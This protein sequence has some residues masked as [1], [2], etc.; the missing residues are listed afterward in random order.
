M[1]NKFTIVLIL[2]VIALISFLALPYFSASGQSISMLDIFETVGDLMEAASDSG[3]RGGSVD[4]DSD[5]K[6]FSILYL[7]SG[8]IL[9]VLSA[10]LLIIAAVQ[11]KS[12]ATTWSIV[13][14]VSMI[15]SVIALYLIIST[16]LP[17]KASFDF[18]ELLEVIGSGFWLSLIC[19]AVNI[20]LS[21]KASYENF[22]NNDSFNNYNN[23]GYNNGNYN[24]G[25]Y[26]NNGYNSGNNNQSIL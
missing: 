18:S 8:I 24:N 20:F 16:M 23:G 26:N 9:P 3:M 15:V 14:T 12:S 4:V 5:I 10:I 1:N 7:V 17:S 11:K 19:F 13:G 25:N 21:K 2:A 22:N 6:L